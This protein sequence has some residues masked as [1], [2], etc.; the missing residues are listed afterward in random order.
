MK[1]RLLSFNITQLLDREDLLHCFDT[2][3]TTQAQDPEALWLVFFDEINAYLEGQH[4][5]DFFLAPLE[6]GLEPIRER[7]RP[8]VR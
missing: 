5:Y 6:D 7:L 3:V 4:V 8:V 2:I 1:A